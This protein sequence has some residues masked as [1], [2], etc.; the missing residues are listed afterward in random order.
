MIITAT[1]GSDYTESR[2]NRGEYSSILKTAPRQEITGPAYQDRTQPTVMPEIHAQA[3]HAAEYNRTVN[4]Q[5][6]MRND[7]MQTLWRRPHEQPP[8][9]SLNQPVGTDASVPTSRP[10]PSPHSAAGGMQQPGIVPNQSPQLLMT[11]APYSQP[12]HAQNPVNQGSMRG[13]AQAPYQQ[14]ASRPTSLSSGPG[15][16]MPQTSQ[17]YSYPQSQP[18]WSQPPQTPQHGYSA[19]TAQSQ[20]SAHP[21][22]SPTPQLR[23]SSSGGQV[24]AGGVPYS[25][26]PGMGQAYGAPAQGMYP[27]EQ[28]PRQYMHQSPAPQPAVTQA[29][30]QQPAPSQW[31][32]NQPQ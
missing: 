4:Q 29:W 19:Y 32:A 15:T 17:N 31:W 11:A 27:T 16:S 23:H 8:P 22:Q 26:M 9:A 20:P 5:R 10:A 6:D 18:M 25:G 3:H 12:I 14:Q 1:L 7:Y 28:T 13:M 24:Q 30:S 21:Q 2:S